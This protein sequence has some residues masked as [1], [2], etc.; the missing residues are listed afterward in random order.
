[1]ILIIM[2]AIVALL[3]FTFQYY[4]KIKK[5]KAILQQKFPESYH[6]VLLDQYLPYKYLSDEQRVLLQ[7][8]IL[9]FIEDKNFWPLGD[10]TITESMCLI[11]AAQASLLVLKET[12]IV[13][14]PWLKNIYIAPS[15]YIEK[16]NFID[17][18]TMRPRYVR[19]LGESWVKGPIVLSWESV[20]HDF[21]Y[22]GGHN[23]IYHEFTHQLDAM[24]SGMDGTP[25]LKKNNDYRMW[26]IVMSKNFLELKK[27]V[28]LHQKS[29]LDQYGSTNEAEFFAVTVEAFFSHSSVFARKHPDLYSLY[30]DYFELDPIL[31]RK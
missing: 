4:K 28:K 19:K 12:S 20:E 30:K 11:I 1:M 14:Y 24:D 16:E 22:G 17:L 9:F 23:I 10:I 26:Q 31:W 18:G 3:V 5:I 8:K 7:K 2:L 15:S 29:D 27:K 13:S 25:I 21:K 6:R